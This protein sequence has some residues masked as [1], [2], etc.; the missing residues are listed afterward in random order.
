[1]CL[2]NTYWPSLTWFSRLFHLLCRDDPMIL[3]IFAPQIRNTAVA[4]RQGNIVLLEG[5]LNWFLSYK[6]EK[7]GVGWVMLSHMTWLDR[8]WHYLR[9]WESPWS[10]HS[11]N[12]LLSVSMCGQGSPH[13]LSTPSKQLLRSRK[14]SRNVTMIWNLTSCETSGETRI[15]EI[16]RIEDLKHFEILS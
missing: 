6:L 9:T 4:C 13:G 15:K 5:S 10:C 8:T 1:M 11:K 14:A 3:R 2:F 12:F 7:N 16:E